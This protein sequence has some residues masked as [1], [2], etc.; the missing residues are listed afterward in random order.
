MGAGGQ[1]HSVE[2]G[3]GSSGT[4]KLCLCNGLDEQEWVDAHALGK[5]NVCSESRCI[6]IALTVRM[7]MEL[8]WCFDDLRF[9]VLFATRTQGG[10]IV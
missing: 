1:C 2:L 6:S 3:L 7:F 9:W 5:L 4:S 10:T 8:R